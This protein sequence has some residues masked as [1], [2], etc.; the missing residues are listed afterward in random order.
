MT[1]GK[2]GAAIGLARASALCLCL[3]RKE[4]NGG[5]NGFDDDAASVMFKR[6]VKEESRVLQMLLCEFFFHG[7]FYAWSISL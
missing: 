3:W 2:E 7:F 5:G 1:Q 4:K 6:L